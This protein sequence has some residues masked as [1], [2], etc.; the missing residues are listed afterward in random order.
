MAESGFKPKYQT[1]ETKLFTALP[2]TIFLNYFCVAPNL[3]Y[4]LHGGKIYSAHSL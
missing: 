2:L 1:P 4:E 3:D